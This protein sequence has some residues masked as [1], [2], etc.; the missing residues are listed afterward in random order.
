M[1]RHRNP[2]D[3]PRAGTHAPSQ[4]QLRVGEVIRHALAEIFARGDLQDPVL[5]EAH[6]TVSEVKVSPDMRHATVFVTKLGGGDM[7]EIM[8][9]L[10]RARG[11]LRSQVARALTTRNTPDL[12]FVEDKSFDEAQHILNILRT[13]EVKADIEARHDEDSEGEDGAP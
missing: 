4:R 7:K 3:D 5:R 2:H 1:P 11:F 8:T 9:A 13:P 10:P 6:I 12:H